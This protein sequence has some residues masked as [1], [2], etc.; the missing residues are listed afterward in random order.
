VHDWRPIWLIPA[1]FAMLV[2]AVFLFSF[3]TERDDPRLLAQER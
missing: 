1:A 2:F 3:S